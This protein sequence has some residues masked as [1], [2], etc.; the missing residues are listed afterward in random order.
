MP[1]RGVALVDGDVV[2]GVV[3]LDDVDVD[4]ST[5]SV[6]VLTNGGGTASVVCDGAPLSRLPDISCAA[7]TTATPNNAIVATT[8]ATWVGPNRDFRCGGSGG[9]TSGGYG[10]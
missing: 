9:R 6:V 10:V 3:E 4:G 5:V 7:R 1:G 2:E 8:S